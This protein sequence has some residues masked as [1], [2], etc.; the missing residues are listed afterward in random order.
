MTMALVRTEEPGEHVVVSQV[1]E[2]VWGAQRMAEEPEEWFTLTQDGT[3]A[4]AI[5]RAK[6]RWPTL[7]IYVTDDC[8]DCGGSGEV[9]DGDGPET[10]GTCDGEGEYCVMWSGK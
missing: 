10:C 9:D 3:R 7:Q 4:E 5:D 2:G 1:R 6:V 8:H